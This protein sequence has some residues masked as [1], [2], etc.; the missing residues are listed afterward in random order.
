MELHQNILKK[1]DAIS[2]IPSTFYSKLSDLHQSD[3]KKGIEKLPLEGFQK[4]RCY[5]M[6]R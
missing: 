6:Q 3:K 5:F 4:L 2:E 1:L